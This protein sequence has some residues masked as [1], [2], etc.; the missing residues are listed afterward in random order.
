MPEQPD[1]AVLHDNLED[2]YQ[3]VN[4]AETNPNLVSR[5]SEN[6]LVPWLEA[7]Q[8]PWLRNL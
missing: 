6:E 7:T 5:L 1:A 3:L 2:R 4:L 8:D